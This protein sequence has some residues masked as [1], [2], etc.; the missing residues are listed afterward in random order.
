M[1]STRITLRP[2]RSTDVDDL[3]LWGGDDRVTKSIHFNTLTSK[4]DALT[5]IEKSSI[6]WRRSI[7]IDDRSIGIVVARPGSDDDRCR[8]EI[9]YALAVD[10]WGQGITPKAVKMAIPLI[11]NDFPEIVRLQALSDANNR[12]SHRVLEKAGFVKEGMFRKY[13]YFKGEIKDVVLY[14]LLSTDSVPSLDP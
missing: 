3:L 12:A 10:Y 1:E 2:Y 4:E 5:F 13:F 14:S 8:A 7:C 6:P 11:F 9:G